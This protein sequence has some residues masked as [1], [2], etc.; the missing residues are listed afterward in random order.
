L[1]RAGIQRGEFRP[2]VNP[3][4]IAAALVGTWDALFLQAWFEKNFDPFTTARNF[5]EVVL[6]GLSN[7]TEN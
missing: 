2:D 3:E 4:S 1:I 7:S 5:L 6:K